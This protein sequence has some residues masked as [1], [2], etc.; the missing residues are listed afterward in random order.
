MS[1]SSAARRAR[2]SS[3][4]AIASGSCASS[5]R[6]RSPISSVIPPACAAAL[7]DARRG[8]RFER[9]PV[10]SAFDEAD[11]QLRFPRQSPCLAE[12]PR[13]SPPLLDRAPRHTE[14]EE[15]VEQDRAPMAVRGAEVALDGRRFG[16]GPEAGGLLQSRDV[17]GQRHL[18]RRRRHRADGVTDHQLA[19]DQRHVPHHGV[20]GVEH[21]AQAGPRTAAQGRQR[22]GE[23]GPGDQVVGRRRRARRA[24]TDRRSRRRSDPPRRRRGARTRGGTSR[25]STRRRRSP[26]RCS[27]GGA[28]T[29]P[30]PQPPSPSGAPAASPRP[31]SP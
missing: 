21:L 17:T 22:V 20:G 10:A 27:A 26:T 1:V 2:P 28:S 30:T 13:R 16:G 3:A 23:A 24:A 5:A 7:D 15:T 11:R 14:R 19:P 18:R 25:G 29:A 8:R 12:R 9:R 4:G 6:S 31:R